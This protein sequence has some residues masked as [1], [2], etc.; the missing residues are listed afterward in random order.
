[1]D[2]HLDLRQCLESPYQQESDAGREEFFE[3]ETECLGRGP[4]WPKGDCAIVSLVHVT[5]REPTGEAY[6][7]TEKE[8][9]ITTVKGLLIKSDCQGPR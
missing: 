5:F 7:E 2:V 9:E 1:M 8:F 3:L 4:E 6:R